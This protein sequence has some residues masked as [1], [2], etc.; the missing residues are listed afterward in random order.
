MNEKQR[1]DYGCFEIYVKN[2]SRK[3]KCAFFTF[4]SFN[5]VIKQ[6]DIC[7]GALGEG[8]GGHQNDMHVRM[9]TYIGV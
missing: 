7:Y 8:G 4:R 2:I 3:E 5:S 6:G 9:Y 1:D